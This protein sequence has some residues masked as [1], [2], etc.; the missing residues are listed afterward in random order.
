MMIERTV[1]MSHWLRHSRHGFSLSTLS[2]LRPV[3]LGPHSCHTWPPRKE[4]KLIISI[5]FF[6][7]L[8]MMWLK[9]IFPHTD[10]CKDDFQ[11]QA[12]W[13][14]CVGGIWERMCYDFLLPLLFTNLLFKHCDGRPT[15]QLP[16]YNQLLLEDNKYLFSVFFVFSERRKHWL[17]LKLGPF[18][19]HQVGSHNWFC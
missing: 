13:R 11:R 7:F 14:G 5:W 3:S 18:Q 2:S 10:I 12:S 19:K 9:N 17:P 8:L 1:Q 4:S 15:K 16:S 6:S